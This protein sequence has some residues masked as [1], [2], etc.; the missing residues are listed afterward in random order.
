MLEKSGKDVAEC[1][2]DGYTRIQMPFMLELSS[3]KAIISPLF[4]KEFSFHPHFA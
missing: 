1:I 4:P 3:K 2:S